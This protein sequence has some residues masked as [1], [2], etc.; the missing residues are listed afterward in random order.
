MT[1]S[2]GIAWIRNGIMYPSDG[3]GLGCR[4]IGDMRVQKRVVSRT[5]GVLNMENELAESESV[6]TK[7]TSMTLK[8]VGTKLCAG[9]G[10]PC[11]CRPTF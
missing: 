11:A 6:N 10:A 7:V 1:M 4:V 9:G 2:L 5:R 3:E 8:A